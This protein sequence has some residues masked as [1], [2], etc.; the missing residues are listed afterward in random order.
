M[1][2]KILFKKLI[3]KFGYSLNK[4]NKS[5][6]V[7]RLPEDI[8]YGD[9]IYFR[10]KSTNKIP[11]FKVDTKISCNCVGWSFSKDSN[12]QFV[13]LLKEY[14]NNNNIKYENSVLYIYYNRFK[15]TNLEELFFGECDEVESD[16]KYMPANQL[17]LPW[18]NTPR[19]LGGMMGLGKENGNQLFGPVSKIKGQLE[20][21]RV[22]T[23]YESIK[24]DGFDI[25]K[26]IIYGYFLKN[27]T[28]YRF[29]INSGNHRVPALSVLGYNK[30]PATFDPRTPRFI[31]IEQVDEWPQVKNGTVSRNI[32]KKIFLRYFEKETV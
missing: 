26:I 24:N 16:L 22:T 5:H 17:L 9:L 28:D 18:E 30:I 2:V 11:I 19:M 10:F 12:H 14:E 6:K 4:T 15:P 27:K 13:K 23:T 31:D 3:N 8:P 25:N 32:A 1:M 29:L 21:K 20:F 7:S